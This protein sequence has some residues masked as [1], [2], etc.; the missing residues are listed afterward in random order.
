[1]LPDA[2][3]EKIFRRLGDGLA[4]GSDLRL[5]VPVGSKGVRSEDFQRL[6]APANGHETSISEVQVGIAR[7]QKLDLERKKKR[8]EH[9]RELELIKAGASKG[10]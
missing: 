3:V 10:L 1:M 4:S 7:E 9:E 5:L 8:E 6:K 2:A